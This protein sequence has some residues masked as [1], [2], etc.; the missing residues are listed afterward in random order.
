M[1]IKFTTTQL[2]DVEVAVRCRLEAAEENAK[3]TSR[4]VMRWKGIHEKIK[5]ALTTGV[6]VSFEVEG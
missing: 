1:K 5:K 6:T 2:I 4:N 3:P